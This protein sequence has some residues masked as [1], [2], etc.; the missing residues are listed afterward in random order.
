MRVHQKKNVYMH[1]RNKKGFRNK[2]VCCNQLWDY[3]LDSIIFLRIRFRVDAISGF[4]IKER[5]L[6]VCVKD[7]CH[8]RVKLLFL[9]SIK[10]KLLRFLLSLILFSIELLNFSRICIQMLMVLWSIS[11]IEV[12]FIPS[13]LM[14]QNTIFLTS[15][16]IWSWITFI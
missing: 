4:T 16:G 7:F 14:I 9:Y 1:E 5:E 12:T 8:G 13:I 11:M 15:H 3:M 2:L 6:L 10:P